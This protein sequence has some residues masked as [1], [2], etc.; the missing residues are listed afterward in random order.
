MTYPLEQLRADMAEGAYTPGHDLDLVRSW[1][2][3]RGGR[4]WGCPHRRLL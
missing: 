2:D 3:L 1:C 4:G